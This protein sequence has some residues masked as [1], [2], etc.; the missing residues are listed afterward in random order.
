MKKGF[1]KFISNKFLVAVIILIMVVF[2]CILMKNFTS[3][4]RYKCTSSDYR[5]LNEQIVCG[6]D[7]IINKKNYVEFKTKLEDFIKNNKKEGKITETSIYFRDLEYGPTFGIN[8]YLT[9][10]PAS[11]L[12][13]PLMITYLTLSE[14]DPSLFDVEVYYTGSEDRGIKQSIVPK[15]SIKQNTK[16]FIRDVIEYMIKYSDNKS[17]Y[18]L[19][20]YLN[21]I[22]TNQEFLKDT[23][24][25]LGIID[26]SNQLEETIN[27][28]SYAGIFTQLFN[29]TYFSDKKTSEMALDFL[30]DTDFRE[31]IVAGVPSGIKVAH[32]FGERYDEDTGVK[33][34]HDC[35]I[36][37]YPQNP[38]LLCIMTRGNSMY[39]LKNTISEIS[40]MLYEE[41]DSR[42]I[43]D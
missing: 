33:Q 34:L 40:K 38:Y 27:V 1:K 15:K 41:F 17:Y 36:V 9:F 14:S 43:Q 31:G 24:I 5:L 35:G 37:Y 7:L 6:E 29:S 2:L 13:L 10:S 28:K 11:L 25:D 8:E 23:F 16:Y 3:I 39:D 4:S 20:E 22:S 12:K 21:K 26:P 42:K 30:N 32:K 19:L 18:V